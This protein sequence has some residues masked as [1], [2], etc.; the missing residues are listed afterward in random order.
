MNTG[1]ARMGRIVYRLTFEIPVDMEAVEET[2]LLA[3]LAVG[4]LYGEAAV[5]LDAGYAIDTDAR[6]VVIDGSTDIGCA[7]ARI[8]IGFCTR[9]FGGDT[10]SMV[11][12]DGP[13]PKRPSAVK[14]ACGA[15]T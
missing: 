14:Q 1:S 7:V 13:V 11:R 9:E 6:V 3:I 4:C 5:R 12:A 10:F 2:L 15:G 8:F